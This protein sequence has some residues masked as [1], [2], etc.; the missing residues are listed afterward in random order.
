MPIAD[1]TR[2]RTFPFCISQADGFFPRL[3]GLLG[4]DDLDSNKGLHI[5]PCSSIHT[6]GM[7]YAVDVLFLDKQGRVVHLIQALPPNK[8]TK[9]V[10]SAQSVL[11]LSAGSISEQRIEVGDILNIKSDKTHRP[12][13]DALKNLFHWPLNV[14][15]AMPWSKF[16]L[17]AIS[18]WLV[19]SEP[20][21]LGI[22][23]HN[24]LLLTLFLTRRKSVD[25]SYRILDWAVPIFVLTCVMMLRGAQS[26]I[27]TLT[28]LSNV[29]QLIIRLY[30][31]YT[32]Q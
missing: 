20:L 26:S 27:P 21:N 7:K 19:H 10:S 25:T 12:N 32:I 15:I 22:I 2:N 11:E 4:T 1:L 28:A 3:I 29:L 9:M 5:V 8:M 24:T 17:L 30:D 14:F 6:F 18:D 31:P 13:L 23:I 16:V